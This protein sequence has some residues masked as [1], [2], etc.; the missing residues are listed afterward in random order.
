MGIERIRPANQPEITK[1]R[2][3]RFKLNHSELKA[4]GSILRHT[5]QF[6]IRLLSA[7]DCVSQHF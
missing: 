5:S 1:E 3:D 7:K 6:W 4:F 2:T